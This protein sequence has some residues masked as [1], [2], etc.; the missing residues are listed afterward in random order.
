MFI[1]WV[2]QEM[3]FQWSVHYCLLKSLFWWAIGSCIKKSWRRGLRHRQIASL[4]NPIV[5]NGVVYHFVRWCYTCSFKEMQMFLISSLSP[6]T[7]SNKNVF[8]HA[9]VAFFNQIKSLTSFI[10][11]QEFFY[12]QY[13]NS[14]K[15]SQSFAEIFLKMCREQPQLRVGR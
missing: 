2:S 4:A 6:C 9:T 11:F 12:K 5:Y 13:L 8:L 15:V 3:V 14:L 1:G 7:K 10:V